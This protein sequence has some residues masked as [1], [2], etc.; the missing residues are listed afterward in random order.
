MAG[1]MDFALRVKTKSARTW[2]AKHLVVVQDMRPH[3][4]EKIGAAQT[5]NKNIRAEAACGYAIMLTNTI[6]GIALANETG[7]T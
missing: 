5:I 6:H 4:L 1:E 3:M 2:S 7:L